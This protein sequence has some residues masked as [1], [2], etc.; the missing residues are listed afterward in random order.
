MEKLIAVMIAVGTVVG[1]ASSPDQL[2]KIQQCRDDGNKPY[3]DSFGMLRHCI[4]PKDQERLDKLELACVSAG[5]TVDYYFGKYE[6]C[7]GNPSVKVN[8]N[9]SGSGFKPYCPPGSKGKVYGC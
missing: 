2:A 7:K 5:G 3:V 9:N 8:V 4:S 6:N 1:C